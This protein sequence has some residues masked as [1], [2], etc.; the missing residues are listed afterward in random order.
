MTGY[1]AAAPTGGR[2]QLSALDVLSRAWD[3]YKR[4]FARSAVM[5]G[6]VFGV[7]NLFQVLLRGSGSPRLLAIVALVLSIGGTALLEGGLVEIVRGLHVDGD[8]DASVSEAFGRAGGELG[9]LVGVSVLSAIGF[10]I[11]F[12]LFVVP[13]FILMTR[14]AVAVPVAMLEKS[15]ARDALRRSRDIVAGNGW[16]IFRVIL[17]VC[18][19]TFVVTLPFE[20]VLQHA[21]ALGWWAALTISSMLT[22][23]YFAHAITVAYYMLVEPNRPVV[24]DRGH[25]WESGWDVQGAALPPVDGEPGVETVADEQ[26]RRFDEYQQR[27][28]Q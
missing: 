17:G 7:L 18:A 28:G 22:A 15:T 3:L 11:G 8:D 12:I 27:W 9:T 19:V 5:A 10:T 2:V 23:P 6:V 20:L 14:W 26:Q 4:L 13:G 16:G 25:H 1:A 21:G 24:L